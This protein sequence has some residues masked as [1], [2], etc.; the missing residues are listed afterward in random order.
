MSTT[1]RD[2]TERIL[3]RALWEEGTEEP[4]VEADDLVDYLEG[5]ADLETIQRVER[6]LETDAPTRARHAEL[7]RILDERRSFGRQRVLRRNRRAGLGAIALIAAM[8]LIVL[9]PRPPDEFRSYEL[10]DARGF[11]AE[12]RG[13]PEEPAD[14]PDR[15]DPADQTDAALWRLAPAGTLEL[16]LLPTDP[17]GI[18]A[19]PS[20]TV[21]AAQDEGPLR[22]V[23]DVGVRVEE[24]D[25]WTAFVVTIPASALGPQPGL[26][27]LLI[28][29]GPRGLDADDV[30]DAGAQWIERS[31]EIID[32]R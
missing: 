16:T 3:L 17:A 18:G 8:L 25:D 6:A 13:A 24:N 23:K 10:V 5:S 21:L 31:V 11:V 29:L 27:R 7:G 15:P 28:G 1:A 4:P 9:L 14:E 26:R 32:V 22:V 12:F 30:D 2:E 19:V 20:V